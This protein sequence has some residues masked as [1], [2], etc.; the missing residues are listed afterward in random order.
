M[1]IHYPNITVMHEVEHTVSLSFND[2]SNIPVVNQMISA[3]K[4]IYN[5]F[6]SGMYHKPH[7]IFKSESYEF[8]NMNIRLLSGNDTR[9]AV[10][11]I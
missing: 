8:H 11:F 5:L 6:G 2:V 1:K 9:M 7:S 3:H 4:A 10:H